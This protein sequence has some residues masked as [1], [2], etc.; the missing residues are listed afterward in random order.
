[1]AGHLL[2]INFKLSVPLEQYEHAIEHGSHAIAGVAGLR[3]KI[4]IANAETQEAGGFYCFDTREAADAYLDGPI[5]ANLK[6]APFAHDVS[7][8][9]FDY[10]ETATAVTRGPVGATLQAVS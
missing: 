6:S 5:V 4:W 8:K 2:Q 3:W 7:V 10:L 1:M 9:Q